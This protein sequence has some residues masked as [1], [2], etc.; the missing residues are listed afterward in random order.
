MSELRRRLMV[1]GLLAGATFAGCGPA[2]EGEFES[3]EASLAGVRS[4]FGTMCQQEYQNG[5]QVTLWHANDRCK[6]FNDRLDDTDTKAF[7]NNLHN[8]KSRWEDTQD[9]KR[10]ETVDLLFSSVHG[11]TEPET[12]F[13]SMWD[14]DEFVDTVNMR[15]GD[16]E[17]GLS[18]LSTYSCETLRVSDGHLKDRWRAA[19]RGGLRFVT[20]SHATLWDGSTT[21][22]VGEDFASGL[23]HAQTL[24]YAWKDA[25][26]DWYFEN[27]AAVMATGISR[28]DCKHRRKNMRWTDFADFP[29]RRDTNVNFFCWTK[30]ADL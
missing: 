4:V 26:S 11:G 23:Q 2:E 24:R 13:F 1:A 19:M 17:R 7:Y 6:W 21:D 5:W 14:Q 8:A 10:A 27:D 20:G 28:T 15:L 18:I 9:H 22:E 16:E 25:V 30:W 12:A 3:V 29:R